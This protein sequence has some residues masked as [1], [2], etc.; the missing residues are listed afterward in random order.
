KL[1]L[2]DAVEAVVAAM[3][4]RCRRRSRIGLGQAV[5]GETLIAEQPGVIPAAEF[6]G[7]RQTL[8]VLLLIIGVLDLA[9]HERRIVDTE[10]QSVPIARLRIVGPG[11]GGIAVE[12]RCERRDVLVELGLD[13]RADGRERRRWTA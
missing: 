13:P 2:G 9:D 7:P 8:G 11:P 10:V 12:D 6:D 1:L 5:G 3:L 4:Q